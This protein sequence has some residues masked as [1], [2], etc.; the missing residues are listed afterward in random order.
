MKHN[1]KTQASA[2]KTHGD[3]GLS[4]TVIDAT[5][6]ED[7]APP[8]AVCSIKEEHTETE[9]R[10]IRTSTN[11]YMLIYRRQDGDAIAEPNFANSGDDELQA[12]LMERVQRENEQARSQLQ[13]YEN[14]RLAEQKRIDKTKVDIEKFLTLMEQ[15][16]AIPVR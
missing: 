9:D 7:D 4:A 1:A 14:A 16:P 2:A 5:T 6:T 10:G 11:A 13:E 8:A 15:H 3:V 12:V